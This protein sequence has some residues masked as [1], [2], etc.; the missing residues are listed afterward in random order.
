MP[1]LKAEQSRRV[2]ES[3]IVMDLSDLE[4]QASEIVSL[5][6]TE[7]T[8][9]IADGKAAADRESLK[10]RETARQAG[11]A[12]GFKAGMEQGVKQGR[13]E[14]L[15]AVSAQVN[16][17]IARW[18]QTL[19]LFHQN[20]PSHLADAKT[21]VVRLALN[22]A[23]RVTHQEA[24]RNRQVAPG[25]CEDAL[26]MLTAAR[27]VTLQVNPVEVELLTQFIPQLLSALQG[28][29]DVKIAADA[30]MSPGG[31]TLRFGEGEI[32]ARLE[33]QLRRISEELLGDSG[34]T[35]IP[36]SDVKP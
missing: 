19:E 15:A 34:E 32:D 18:S 1:I 35:Q 36:A 27:R 5:G 24:L 13:E 25:V 6:Q 14:A 7:A 10:I 21:D 29:E 20:L 23:G 26:R 30:G 16:E 11:H 28:I 3:V 2:R 8:R 22:V 12:E 4:R 31:C 9:L 17:L 33:T